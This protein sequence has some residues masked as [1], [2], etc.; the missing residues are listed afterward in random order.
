MKKYGDDLLARQEEKHLEEIH[1]PAPLKDTDR[2]KEGT[3]EQ[4][5]AERT[6]F[7]IGGSGASIFNHPLFNIT[8]KE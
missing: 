6:A 4:K 2:P 7:A 5:T 3:A 1:N 8:K